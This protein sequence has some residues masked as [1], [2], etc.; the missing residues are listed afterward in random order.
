MTNNENSTISAWFI[1]RLPAEWVAGAPAAIAIDRDEITI[2]I[3]IEPPSVD[4]NASDIDLSEAF[5]GRMSGWREDT[6]EQ[7]MKIAAQAEHRYDRKVAWALVCGDRS[8]LFNNLAAPVMTRLRQPERMVLDTLV[9]ANVARSR[10][11]AVAWCVRL[12]GRNADEWLADLRTAMM[13]VESVRAA[14][15]DASAS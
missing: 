8:E 1:G 14:G 15:P 3:T 7:R 5:V 6:R 10:A 11:D 13:T 12:V 2:T 9:E 4:A